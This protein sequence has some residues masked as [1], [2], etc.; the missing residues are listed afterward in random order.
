[1]GA[2]SPEHAQV[3]GRH[4]GWSCCV[5]MV[6]ACK[7]ASRCVAGTWSNMYVSVCA[8]AAQLQLSC[9]SSR[10]SP[11]QNLLCDIVCMHTQ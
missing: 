4:Y 7:H 10:C 6:H 2:Y 11:V 9:G 8:A 5:L 1:M 3:G